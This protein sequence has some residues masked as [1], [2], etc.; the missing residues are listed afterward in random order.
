MSSFAPPHLQ[1]KANNNF[2]IREISCM[3]PVSQSEEIIKCVNNEG[4][5]NDWR[6]IQYVGMLDDHD[7]LYCILQVDQN[8]MKHVND[9]G[10]TNDSQNKDN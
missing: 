4:C 9:E 1:Q 6:L 8:D 2:A 3:I 7:P 10:H 5:T